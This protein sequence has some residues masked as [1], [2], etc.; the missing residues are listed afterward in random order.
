MFIILRSCENLDPFSRTSKLV[1][2]KTC[3]PCKVTEKKYT[4]QALQH[5]AGWNMD[6]DWRWFFLWKMGGY[7][8]LPLLMVQK[9]PTTTWDVYKI[10]GSTNN[11]NWWVYRIS[12]PSTV[13]LYHNPSA[14][15]FFFK[16]SESEAQGVD[17]WTWGW[18]ALSLYD[19]LDEDVLQEWNGEMSNGVEFYLVVL[20]SRK[21]RKQQRNMKEDV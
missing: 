14:T 17:L 7:S 8:S 15:F 21:W 19:M 3:D 4:P 1:S 18:P 5:L 16:T 6:P 2:R 13:S 9:S 11:L 10:M 12:E 20:P